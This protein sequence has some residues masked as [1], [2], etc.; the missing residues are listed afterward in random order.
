VCAFVAAVF[1]T[2]E[3]QHNDDAALLAWYRR[4]ARLS[5]VVTGAL[6]LAGTVVLHADAPRLLHGLLTR[7]LPLMI[8][9]AVCG[10][11]SL[12]L[13]GRVNPRLAQLVAVGAAGTVVVGWGVA[14]YPYLLGTHLTIAEAAAPTTP[15]WALTAVAAAALVL[16][17]P[18]FALLYVLHQRGELDTG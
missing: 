12:A 7:G 11:A 16:V 8:L 13:A 14:Q 2:A 15:R 18:S 5:A 4:R 3:A 1:L 9:S 10:L 6:A 17:V